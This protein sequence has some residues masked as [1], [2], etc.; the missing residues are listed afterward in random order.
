VKVI[1]GN[2]DSHED[3]QKAASNAH[4]TGYMIGPDPDNPG[5][6]AVKVMTGPVIPEMVMAEPVPLG[7]PQERELFSCP[8]PVMQG[9]QDRCGQFQFPPR[10]GEGICRYVQEPDPQPTPA[11]EPDRDSVMLLSEEEWADLAHMLGKFISTTAHYVTNA[12]QESEAI[13]NLRRQH[14]LAAR[15][16]QA[17]EET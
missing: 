16:I 10:C 4:L 8:S 15:I 9:R 7:Q 2:H 6:F 17:A 3:A 11:P 14:A 1:S 13:V 5:K 12:T